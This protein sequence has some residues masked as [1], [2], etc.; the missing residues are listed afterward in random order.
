MNEAD[1]AKVF[2]AMQR[3]AALPAN[4]GYPVRPLQ[5]IRELVDAAGSSTLRY[6]RSCGVLLSKAIEL[7]S[8]DLVAHAYAL[9]CREASEDITLNK[10]K[11][12]DD[13][14]NDDN[15][16][17][18]SDDDGGTHSV[19]EARF[20]RTAATQLARF[21]FL[22]SNND[23][24][25]D[26]EDDDRQRR[27]TTTLNDIVLVDHA[28]RDVGRLTLHL[29]RVAD[30]LVTRGTVRMRV[31][32]PALTT[33]ASASTSLH[34]PAAVAALADNE[35]LLI[36]DAQLVNGTL[37]TAFASFDLHAADDVVRNATGVL[38]R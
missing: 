23:N 6:E 1:V 34:A 16:N 36:V 37:S 38:V 35:E 3:D 5:A 30:R 22:R 7:F 18:N 17:D 15:D 24:D 11:H 12:D 33:A 14:D 13:D 28:S 26:D 29:E 25:S 31:L 4:A 10:S 27:M 8:V 2:A 20:L 9:K 19:L 21:D 32:L